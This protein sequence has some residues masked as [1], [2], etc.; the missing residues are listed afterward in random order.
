MGITLRKK[1][2]RC[3]NASLNC[4]STRSLSPAINFR[5][6]RTYARP[7]SVREVPP[8]CL[9]PTARCVSLTPKPSSISFNFRHATRKCTPCSAAAALMEPVRSTASRR[10]TRHSLSTTLPSFSNQK[11]EHGRIAAAALSQYLTLYNERKREARVLSKARLHMGMR[12]CLCV[13]R[14]HQ[15]LAQENKAKPQRRMAGGLYSAHQLSEQGALIV[16]QR[17]VPVERRGA[18]GGVSGSWHSLTASRGRF[19]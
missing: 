19:S 18:K 5:K 10:A 9:P 11:L 17:A 4:L 1:F 6:W 7:S 13:W 14:I 3:L 2:Y 16:T 15:L 12:G 8:P